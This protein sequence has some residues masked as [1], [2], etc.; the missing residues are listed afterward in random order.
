M[1]TSFQR[2]LTVKGKKQTGRKTHH[3]LTWADTAGYF[4]VLEDISLCQK[5]S[6]NILKIFFFNWMHLFKRFY[7]FST[8]GNRIN[9]SLF[10]FWQVHV[11]VPGRSTSEKQI[12]SAFPKHSLQRYKED[13]SQIYY[14]YQQKHHAH[15]R[16]EFRLYLFQV[17]SH[18]KEISVKF[19]SINRQGREGGKIPKKAAQILP[20]HCTIPVQVSAKHE[21]YKHKWVLSMGYSAARQ[22]VPSRA[23][24][25]A[26]DRIFSQL[27]ASRE[28]FGHIS[29]VVTKV[30]MQSCYWENDKMCFKAKI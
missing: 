15:L 26:N 12:A 25:N 17:K 11:T 23:L 30:L 2:T 14:F 22:D 3:V 24:Y 4:Q 27:Q 28:H 8:N 1:E 9:F 16:A 7:P 18:F 29:P 10:S 19:F 5:K 13:V 21:D 6:Q 20:L